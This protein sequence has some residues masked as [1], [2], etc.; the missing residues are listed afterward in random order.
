MFHPALAWH[1]FQQRA[2]DFLA[3]AEQARRAALA[4]PPRRPLRLALAAA[5]RAL[6][7]RLEGGGEVASPGRLDAT[8]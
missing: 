5:L 7:A 1:L 6:A 2:R 3:E 4:A 8:G